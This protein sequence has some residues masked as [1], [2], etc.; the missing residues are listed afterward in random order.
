MQST[1]FALSDA[2]STHSNKRWLGWA[3]LYLLYF[4][5]AFQAIITASGL[6][7]PVGIRDS[8]VYTLPWLALVAC[9]PGGWVRPL[10]A[11]LGALMLPFLLANLGY[12]F[13][14]G[15]EMSQ[16]VLYSIFETNK[17]ESGEFVE[18]YAR[19]WMPLMALAA[20]LPA[21]WLWRKVQPAPLSAGARALVISLAMLPLIEP[22]VKYWQGVNPATWNAAM[23]KLE[24]RLSSVNPW[25]FIFAYEGYRDNLK[26]VQDM[27]A[28]LNA[29]LD[30]EPVSSRDAHER[31]TYVLVIGESTNRQRM[32][33]YGYSRDTTPNLKRMEDELLVFQD[34]ITPR[35]YTIEALAQAL[36]FGDQQHP[37]RIY[38][39][40]NIV[41]LMR[42]AGFE[43]WWISNQQTLSQRNTM[44]TA[45]SS[46]ADHAVLLNNNRKQGAAQYDDVVLQ[47]FEQALAHGAAKKFIV[48]HL[49][50]THF[51]FAHRFPADQ[52]RFAAE[53]PSNM[54]EG[55]D[56]TVFNAYDDAIRFNDKVVAA[57]LDK[58]KRKGDYG[59]A[60]YFSDHGEEV[61]DSRNFQGRN[62]NAPSTAM[63][64]VPMLMLPS[65]EY[66]AARDT[67]AW[68]GLKDRAYSNEHFLHT[69][70][71][72]ASLDYRECSA[73]HSLVSA[74]FI[75]SP[76]LIGDPYAQNGLKDFDM[77]FPDNPELKLAAHSR[78][79]EKSL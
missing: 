32:S 22:V 41:S 66:A 26:A 19:G 46:Q 10:L 28:E 13:L 5:L 55:G 39:S 77:L 42:A 68:H 50:G 1:G 30:A 9:L 67:T 53:S 70:C 27:V 18:N 15:Q 29:R 59:V 6:V 47:P 33:L 60:V 7:S 31:Q 35:P 56:A 36:S 71:D 43:T 44:L 38:S 62:E 4:S 20:A 17:G 37:D 73:R 12:F 76:R 24:G 45:L 54:V 52:A 69:W 23:A 8:L 25:Q 16:G 72:L 75:P 51:G 34:V 14:Y 48:V 61:F 21:I 63:Y 58:F 74:Q 79:N 78:K 49:L 65:A 64:T 57:I 11:V 3:Y 40:H 2:P